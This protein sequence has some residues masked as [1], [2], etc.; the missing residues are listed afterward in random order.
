MQ[1]RFGNTLIASA[2]VGGLIVCGAALAQTA[3]PAEPE[4]VFV[5]PA[6]V[7]THPMPASA[8][9]QEITR[10]LVSVLAND[11]DLVGDNIGVRTVNGVVHLSG[12]LRSPARIYRAVELARQ[13]A[14]VVAIDDRALDA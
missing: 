1:A 5:R 7:Y 10:Q 4:T 13:I 6:M 11:H 9:D 14:G 3:A 12:H 8:E 2:A